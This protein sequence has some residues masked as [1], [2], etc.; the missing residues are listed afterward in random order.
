ML[1]ARQSSQGT[2]QHTLAGFAFSGHQQVAE[3]GQPHLGTLSKLLASCPQHLEA[4][5]CL[6]SH[7]VN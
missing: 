7:C 1:A 4:Q 2:I 6:Q 5:L 3:V